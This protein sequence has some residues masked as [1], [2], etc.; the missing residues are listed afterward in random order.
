MILILEVL[1]H[2]LG[3]SE[4]AEGMGQC[5]MWSCEKIFDEAWRT[6]VNAKELIELIY[7]DRRVRIE[8]Q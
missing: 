2:E 4:V 3:A 6:E 7:E 8:L 1:L 5:L